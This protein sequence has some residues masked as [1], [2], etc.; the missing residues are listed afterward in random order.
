MRVL[1][2]FSLILL[3]LLSSSAVLLVFGEINPS[4][5]LD[6]WVTC[7]SKIKVN[8]SG[9]SDY[10]NVMSKFITITSPKGKTEVNKVC[11]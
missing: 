6:D 11:K 3:L 10:E 5:T 2:H 4:V 9:D 1:N 7:S 8:Y